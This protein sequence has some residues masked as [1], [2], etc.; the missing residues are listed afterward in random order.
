MIA[1]D[2]LAAATEADRRRNIR[3]T[4]DMLKRWDKL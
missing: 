2:F 3:F 4:S 1:P